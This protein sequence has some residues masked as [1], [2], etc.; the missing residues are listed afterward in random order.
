MAYAESTVGG[1][2][3][4]SF[5]VWVNSIR[6]YYGNQGENFEEWR[7]EGGLNRVSSYGGTIYNGYNNASYT[8]Q[9]GMNGV[10]SSGNFSYNFNSTVERK[11]AWGTGTTR[12]YRD[13]A[14]NGFGFGSRMDINLNN[15]SPLTSGWVVSNDSV[16]TLYRQ[17]NL[18]NL[19][20]DI[21]D[22]S[23]IWVEFSNPSG[24][25]V[26]A[27]LEFPGLTGGT[28]YLQYNSIG[29]RFTWPLS[30]G[31]RDTLRA[32]LVNNN[33]A[34]IRY[35]L[36][37]YVGGVY[38]SDYRDRTYTIANDSGNANPTFTNFT[39]AD[40]NSAAVAITGSNQVL[41]QN[42]STPRATVTVAN[43]ATA[44][45]QAAMSYY[46][47][48]IGSNTSYAAWS[49]GSNVVQDM[50][51]TDVSGVQ[52]LSARAI[53]SRGNSTTVT[54]SVTVL[55]YAAPSF[56]SKLD[57]KYTNNYDTSSGL[58]V[59]ANG[60]TIANISPMTLT[61]TDKNAVNTTTGVKF[62]LSKGD[63]FSYTGTWTNV[64]TARTAG[65]SA[66][67][68]NLT[69]L[70]SSI[71]AKM[72]TMAPSND[73]IW[74]V[75]FRITDLIS[76]ID[77]EVAIDIGRAIFRIGSDEKVYNKEEQLLVI[78]MISVLADSKTAGIAG[79]TGTITPFTLSPLYVQHGTGA[80]NSSTVLFNIDF[81][82][83]ST[84]TGMRS[85]ALK[86]DG[87]AVGSAARNVFIDTAYVRKGVSAT[88]VAKGLAKGTHAVSIEIYGGGSNV[89]TDTADFVTVVATEFANAYVPITQGPKYAGTVVD[90]GGGGNVWNNP[91]NAA[92]TENGTV[93]DVLEGPGGGGGFPNQLISS[94][95]GFSIPGTATITGIVLEA[96]VFGYS[97]AQ[98]SLIEVGTTTKRSV[99]TPAPNHSWYGTGGLTWQTWGSAGEL[100]GRTDWTPTDINHSSFGASLS[101]F[102]SH[103]T[104][105]DQVDAI[106]ITVFYV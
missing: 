53:D 93:A 13:N 64:T 49:S 16:S 15:P 32:V 18:T 36:E 10:A 5:R 17:A 22:T 92:G 47:F 54:K 82:F 43:K 80:V 97:G 99:T 11:L 45:K 83:Y 21:Y 4:S 98:D 103:A 58:T 24:A 62:D 72:A 30:S 76:T 33:S 60:T 89:T 100:W 37:T 68:T 27:W 12:V 35:V 59:A 94:A 67:T 86:V 87:T 26:N 55:P 61:G 1:T 31:D 7:A 95:H 101:A 71:L 96:L 63:S 9:L 44:N 38:F 28:R 106:R 69:T 41:I 25:Q 79:G 73:V 65:S 74:Y 84:G 85:W 23:D 42:I 102:A 52:G 19:S 75:K 88:I 34:T 57:I 20:Q 46:N 51:P 29:S 104:S 50:G 90:G 48:T 2:Y 56:V 8:L 6:T 77:Y 39:Y 14:G 105:Q 78:P 81:D 66:V 40:T 70:A 3:G 91:S